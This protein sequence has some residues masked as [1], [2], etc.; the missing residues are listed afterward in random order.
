MS[1][2]KEDDVWKEIV[3]WI[4]VGMIAFTVLLVLIALWILSSGNDTPVN[5]KAKQ[6]V[7]A[8][9][10]AAQSQS[11]LSIFSLMQKYPLL[12]WVMLLASFFVIFRPIR[13][14]RRRFRG[15]F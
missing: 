3:P 1:K 7:E 11:Q 10:Q 8:K 2:N 12:F 14:L 9:V 15:G 5:T 13:M 4:S 6:E